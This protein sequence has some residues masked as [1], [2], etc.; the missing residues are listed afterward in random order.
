MLRACGQTCKLE[1]LVGTPPTHTISNI[2]PEPVLLVVIEWVFSCLISA[3]RGMWERT[4]KATGNVAVICMPMDTILVT[5]E[6]SH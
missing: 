6:D 1:K 5:P 3:N 4:M 2:T